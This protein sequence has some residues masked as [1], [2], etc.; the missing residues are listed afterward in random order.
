MGRKEYWFY[1]GWN[2]KYRGVRVHTKA[3]LKA[4]QAFF[5][6]EEPPGNACFDITDH[7]SHSTDGKVKVMVIVDIWTWP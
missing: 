4:M 1:I 7:E 6:Q 3:Q 2:G 5:I